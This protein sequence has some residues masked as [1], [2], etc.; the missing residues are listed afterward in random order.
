MQQ[1]VQVRTIAL[2]LYIND[3]SS[4]C[5]DV[6]LIKY[7]NDTVLYTYGKSATEVALK[8]KKEMH[9]LF[10]FYNQVQKSIMW[11]NSNMYPLFL[12]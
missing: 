1:I 9:V 12:L 8:L 10:C 4:V 7:A 6:D 11:M 5:N 2:S 3:L